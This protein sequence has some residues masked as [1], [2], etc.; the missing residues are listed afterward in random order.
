MKFYLSTY[1]LHENKYYF[2]AE[3]AHLRLKKWLLL[4][5]INAHL[6]MPSFQSKKQKEKRKP[7][8]KAAL[9][10]ISFGL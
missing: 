6:E 10:L 3:M 5:F 1:G 9:P 2:N 7:N 8:G 4:E